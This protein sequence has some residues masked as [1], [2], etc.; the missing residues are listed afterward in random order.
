LQVKICGITN[1]ADAEAAVSYGAD[2]LGFIFAKGSPRCITQET[3]GKIIAALPPFVTTV[4]VFTEGTTEALNEAIARCGIDLIQFHGLFP[5]NV[6]EPFLS[7]AICVVSFSDIEQYKPVKAARAYL[8]DCPLSEKICGHKKEE[9][10]ND[11]S[12]QWDNAINAKKWGKIILAGG[13]T[14]VNVQKAIQHVQPYG[15]DICSGIEAE[16]G[17]KDWV[18]MKQFIYLAKE[19]GKAA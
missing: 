6:I 9:I 4:G 7:R 11:L 19:A 18:K 12:A 1:L 16:K 10:E 13:L 14:T 2:A 15:V 5:Q 8:L 3:A 17:K